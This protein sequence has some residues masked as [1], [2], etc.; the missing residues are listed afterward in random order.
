MKAGQI[1]FRTG[2][3]AAVCQ[4]VSP[5]GRWVWY[6]AWRDPVNDT[7]ERLTIQHKILRDT[8]LSLRAMRD[9]VLGPTPGEHG[10]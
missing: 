3:L 6:S 8:A 10:P 5:D 7:A 2:D 1:L 4:G 9:Q